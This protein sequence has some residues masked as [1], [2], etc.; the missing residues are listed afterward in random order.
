MR[1][2]I[3]ALIADAELTR[4][5]ERARRAVGAFRSGTTHTSADHDAALVEAYRT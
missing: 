3:D 4:R 2:A 1:A 5:I